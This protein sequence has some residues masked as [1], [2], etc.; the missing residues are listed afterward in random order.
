VHVIGIQQSKDGKTGWR[1]IATRRTDA[2]GN[3]SH[4]VNARHPAWFHR[5]RFAGTTAVGGSLSVALRT[6]LVETRIAAYSIKR[7]GEPNDESIVFAGKMQQR[8]SKGFAAISKRTTIVLCWR[9]AGRK[10]FE[11]WEPTYKTDSRGRF[12]I[13]RGLFETASWYVVAIVPGGKHLWTRSP[14]VTMKPSTQNG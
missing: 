4:V 10:S 7:T 8:T 12:R 14:S 9:P 1:T 11:C 6:K 3:F 5:L 13:R 2:Q